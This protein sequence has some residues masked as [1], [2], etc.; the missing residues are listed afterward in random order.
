MAKMAIKDQKYKALKL[1]ETSLVILLLLFLLYLSVDKDRDTCDV[2][3]YLAP[4]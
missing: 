3:N 1:L 2:K 4:L